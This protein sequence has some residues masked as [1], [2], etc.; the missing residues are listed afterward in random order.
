MRNPY[1][2]E[3][4][5]D[6]EDFE[7]HIKIG[8]RALDGIIDE[9][10]NRHA[11]KEQAKNS[12]NYRNIGLGVFGYANMLFMLRIKYGSEEAKIFTDALFNFMFRTAVIEDSI[13]AEELG[14]FPKFNKKVWDSTIIK[15][16]FSPKELED[17]RN[18]K[19]RNCSLLSI[20]PTGSIATMFGLSGG[21]EPEFALA[22]TR[23]TD[24]LKESY[25]IECKSVQDYREK[26][27][28][29]KG[30]KLPDYFVCAADI[31]WRD[32]ID[33]QSIMQKHVDTAISSTI[34]LPKETT[35]EEINDLYLMAWE[36]KLKGVTIYRSGCK[37]E[38]ILT[39][40]NKTNN[41]E[42]NSHNDDGYMPDD[43]KETYRNILENKRIPSEKRGEIKQAHDNVIGLKRKL[44][45]GC[46]SLHCTAFFD[47]DT[48]DLVEVYL[49]K[50]SKGGCANSL[51]GLSR[52]I[53]LA[54]RGGISVSD[55]VD[56]LMSTGSC[57]SYAARKAVKHDTSKGSCCP[58][59]VGYAIKEMWEDFQGK[60]LKEKEPIAAEDVYIAQD[61]KKLHLGKVDNFQF[62]LDNKPRCPECGEPISFE[63]GCNICR[64]CGWS[65]CD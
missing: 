22:Y 25:E 14:A 15:N 33:I 30:S 24:N 4:Y 18:C 17:L 58:L 64:S 57:P 8:I 46:G 42:Q 6:F 2:L 53:S 61:E 39:T 50:G 38:G 16:H 34:N 20:A 36:K 48:S 13:L 52:L 45:T 35:L 41:K 56:Q 21:C 44:M 9:N 54:A 43:F 12:K 7:K 3:A 19:L 29:V 32:R 59:A 37:R 47:A 28:I 1:T 5:F 49:S 31:N 10:L 11:L 65:K 55:I 60:E 27:R 40:D 51:V 62:Q 63:G 23:N 26:L